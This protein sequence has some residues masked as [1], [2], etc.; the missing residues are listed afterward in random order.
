M[1]SVWDP[2]QSHVQ[3]K[4]FKLILT[5]CKLI[6][7]KLGL[8]SWSFLPCLSFRGYASTGTETLDAVEQRLIDSIEAQEK[9]IAR[10]EKLSEKPSEKPFFALAIAASG[11]ALLCAWRL[12][13]ENSKNQ[14]FVQALQQQI[15]VQDEQIARYAH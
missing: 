8:D 2:P 11:F 7:C 1:Q 9:R 14:E 10:I 6:V 5:R 3:Y 15:G 13:S 12:V 4:G